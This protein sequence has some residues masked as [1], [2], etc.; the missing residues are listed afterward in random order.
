MRLTRG[1][2]IAPVVFGVAVLV[3]WQLAVVVL[4]IKPFVLPSPLRIAGLFV[5][6]APIVGRGMLV[7]GTNAAIGFVLGAVVGIV[8]AGVA[9]SIRAVD[10]L[11]QPLVTAASVVPLVALGPVLYTMFGADAQTARQLIAA[12]AVFVPVFVNTLRGLRQVRP[13]HRDLMRS[14]AATRWQATRT[15]TL[16]GALPLVFTGLR[17]GSSLAVI[18]AL[19]AEYFGGPVDGLAT[20]ITSAAAYSNYPLAYAFVLGA[21]LLGLLFFVVTVA[22]ERVASRHRAPAS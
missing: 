20:A 21:I 22:A 7:T 8:L 13:V 6:D 1:S 2:V 11:A 3:L 10:E 14:L 17:I 9:A 16:P 18:S 19:V 12:L 4:D 5:Q 15:V